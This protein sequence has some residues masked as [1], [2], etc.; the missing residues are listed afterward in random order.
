MKTENI[1]EALVLIVK[2]SPLAVGLAAVLAIF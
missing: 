2:L 1:I